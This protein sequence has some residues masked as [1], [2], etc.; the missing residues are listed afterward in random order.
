RVEVA[1]RL[2]ETTALNVDEV[3]VTAGFG[4]PETL[5]RAF[6][7]RVGASPTDYRDRF[8]SFHPA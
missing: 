1:R 4:T 7:R 6:A 5:R 3:A 2:L 8:R